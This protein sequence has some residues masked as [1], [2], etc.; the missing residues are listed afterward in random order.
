[1]QIIIED[2]GVGMDE[3]TKEKIFDPFFTTKDVGEG[4][5]LGL[6]VV[7]GIIQ[8]HHGSIEVSSE[9]GKGTTF[10]INLPY[11]QPK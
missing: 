8:N 11:I 9:L 6:S 7:Y 2:N 5:G 4:T 10:K 1:M 3:E